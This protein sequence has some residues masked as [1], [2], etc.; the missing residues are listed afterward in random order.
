MQIEVDLFSGRP[1]PHW[2]LSAA[3]SGEVLALLDALPACPFGPPPESL[4][5]RGF[6]LTIPGTGERIVSYRGNVWRLKP[7]GNTCFRDS[8]RTLDQWLMSSSL[9]HLDSSVY[10]LLS[11]EVDLSDG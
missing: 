7:A 5:F 11:Q 9:S 8:D 4:A 6:V 2:E 3:E 10:E 1:N